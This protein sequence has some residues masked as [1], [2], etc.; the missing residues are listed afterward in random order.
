M[1]DLERHNIQEYQNGGDKSDDEFVSL[2]CAMLIDL[3]VDESE[4]LKRGGEAS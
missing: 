2:G 3:R 4:S 1:W